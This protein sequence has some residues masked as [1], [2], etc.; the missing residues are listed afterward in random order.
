MKSLSIFCYCYCYHYSVLVNLLSNAKRATSSGVICLNVYRK[1]QDGDK[2][3]CEIV[4]EVADTGC[5]ISE[6]DFKHIFQ[7]FRSVTRT[8]RGGNGAGLGLSISECLAHLMGGDISVSSCL[9]KGST[10]TLRYVL[11]Y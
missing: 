10:F 8:S 6:S 9:G 4:F 7:R 11:L 5:G 1:E 2:N 3:D